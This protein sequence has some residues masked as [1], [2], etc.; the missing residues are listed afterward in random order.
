MAGKGSK[1]RPEVGTK[2]QDEWER[3]FGSKEQEKQEK[4]LPLLED[5]SL[6]GDYNR[7]YALS[8]IILKNHSIQS[9]YHSEEGVVW[10]G[11]ESAGVFKSSQSSIF[12]LYSKDKTSMALSERSVWAVAESDDGIIWVGTKN[13][14][15]NRVV[16]AEHSISYFKHDQKDS[17]S[18][19]NNTIRSIL[20]DDD[21]DLWIG[22]DFGLNFLKSGTDTFKSYFTNS[23]NGSSI[24]SNLIRPIYQT[25]D[26][27]VIPEVLQSYT[28]FDIIK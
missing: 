19:S 24:S 5:F 9:L 22:T 25:K 12:S 14:G 7:F 11:T 1:R 2:Y 6:N 21:K 20:I 18:I 16:P 4:Y 8:K 10:A 23:K 13:G 26:G 17:S 15:L 28:G 3:I 27:I